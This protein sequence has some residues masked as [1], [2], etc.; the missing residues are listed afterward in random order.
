[1]TKRTVNMDDVYA[2]ISVMSNPQG[3]N[4]ENMYWR[5]SGALDLLQ[6]M[7]LITQREKNAWLDYYIDKHIAETG[8]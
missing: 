3:F 2:W 5:L 7:E 6:Y 4:N 8:V 1:M